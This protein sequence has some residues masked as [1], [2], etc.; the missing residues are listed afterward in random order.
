MVLSEKKTQNE[1]YSKMCINQI[2]TPC[3]HILQIHL[4]LLNILGMYLCL[5]GL[6]DMNKWKMNEQK[7]FPGKKYI[8]HECMEIICS[9]L[10]NRIYY[11]F[12]IWGHKKEQRGERKREGKREE[13]EKKEER[14]FCNNTWMYS[15]QNEMNWKMPNM[16]CGILQFTEQLTGRCYIFIVFAPL[17]LPPCFLHIKETTNNPLSIITEREREGYKGYI[18]V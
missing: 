7:Y 13:R 2:Y 18:W 9:E 11:N 17:L 6:G 15:L 12:C 14:K 10:R 5:G 8:L 1:I 4:Y 16:P 3:P